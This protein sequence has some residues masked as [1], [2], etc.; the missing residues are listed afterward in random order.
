MNQLCNE[1]GEIFPNYAPQPMKRTYLCE[2]QEH[3]GNPNT[4]RLFTLNQVE[5]YSIPNTLVKDDSSIF[6][7]AGTKDL[8]RELC[9]RYGNLESAEQKP[10]AKQGV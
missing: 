1:F 10:R 7:K 6:E 8:L 5:G 9:S 3:P 4:F 2:E